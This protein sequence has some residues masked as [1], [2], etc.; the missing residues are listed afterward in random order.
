M[1]HGMDYHIDML[2][3]T[4]FESYENLLEKIRI[5]GIYIY[6]E[7]CKQKIMENLY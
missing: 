2:T 7:D 1:R 3:S 4:K 5:I 6:G